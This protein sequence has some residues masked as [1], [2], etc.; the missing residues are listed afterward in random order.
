MN[1][2]WIFHETNDHLNKTFF[3]VLFAIVLLIMLSLRKSL[4][5]NYFVSWQR[6]VSTFLK[7]SI[8][9]ILWCWLVR[10]SFVDVSLH[11][12]FINFLWFLIERWN[13]MFSRLSLLILMRRVSENVWKLL[14]IP[15]DFVFALFIVDEKFLWND[16]IKFSNF[17]FQKM[18]I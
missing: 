8:E 11:I 12:S 14:N 7:H 13:L 6:S 1:F 4:K 18:R 16:F 9:N 5:A 3:F 17:T 10:E 15:K 2:F